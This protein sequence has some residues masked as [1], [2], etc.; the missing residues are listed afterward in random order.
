MECTIT[1]WERACALE[2][3][4]GRFCDPSVQPESGLSV[5]LLGVTPLDFSVT[6][7]VEALRNVFESAGIPGEKLLGN[8]KQL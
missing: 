3:V 7:N 6:G 4:A 8:G 1:A 5:N 2:A